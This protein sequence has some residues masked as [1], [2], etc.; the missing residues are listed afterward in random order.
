MGSPEEH[1]EGSA[2]APGAA[3]TTHAPEP[4][5]RGPKRRRFGIQ[6]LLARLVATG[7]VIGIGAALG[8]ILVA[9]KVQG[10]IT[11]LV[12]ALVSVLLS[13]V[14]WSSMQL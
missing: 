1:A 11:G 7:G 3:A 10:W 8:A 13:A 12:V 14:L 2:Q 6:R 4:S 9:S 5:G